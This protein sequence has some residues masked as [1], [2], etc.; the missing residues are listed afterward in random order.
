[1]VRP[2]SEDKYMSD[3]E[4]AR[5]RQAAHDRVQAPSS[6]LATID[7]SVTT[8]PATVVLLAW[9]AVGIPLAIGIWI[10]IQKAIVLIH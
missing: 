4:L 9:L 7:G 2:V 8:T 5:E 6:T 10:T 3:E 1:M